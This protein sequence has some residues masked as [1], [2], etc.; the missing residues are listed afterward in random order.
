MVGGGQGCSQVRKAGPALLSAP[1]SEQ[2]QVRLLG[3]SSLPPE[4]TGPGGAVKVGLGARL[5]LPGHP[6]QVNI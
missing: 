2:G 4:D 6:Q 1:R 5:A 3:S